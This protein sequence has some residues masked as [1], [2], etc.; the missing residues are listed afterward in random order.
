M[1]DADRIVEKVVRELLQPLDMARDRYEKHLRT[2]L[3]IGTTAYSHTSIEIQ[4][5]ITVYTVLATGMDDF[6]LPFDAM[7][8]FT[9]RFVQ[10]L[11][12][13]SPALVVFADNLRRMADF[14]LVQHRGS[15]PPHLTSSILRCL[16]RTYRV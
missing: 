1:F 10:G 4:A 15:S 3:A 7:D 12:Q 16:R 5:H 2:A 14:Y 8:Q 13:L 6:D 9:M 11:P